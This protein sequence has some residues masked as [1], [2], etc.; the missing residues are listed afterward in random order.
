MNAIRKPAQ[1][2]ALA[3]IA[4][5]ALTG[6]GDSPT[7]EPIAQVPPQALTEVPTTATDST[8]AYTTFAAGLVATETGTALGLNQI[9]SVPTS[10]TEPPLPI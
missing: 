6:C 7:A 4:G 8:R 3:L 1:W 9:A 2:A 10:E 5:L